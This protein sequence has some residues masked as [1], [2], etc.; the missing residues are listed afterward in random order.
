MAIY[1]WRFPHTCW[2]PRGITGS[3]IQSYGSG[4]HFLASFC[5]SPDSLSLTILLLNFMI[6]RMKLFSNANSSIYIYFHLFHWNMKSFGLLVIKNLYVGWSPGPAKSPRIEEK[7]LTS[8]LKGA[9]SYRIKSLYLIRPHISKVWVP[10]S[11]W[12]QVFIICGYGVRV[13]FNKCIPVFSEALTLR[14]KTN[15]ISTCSLCDSGFRV[16]TPNS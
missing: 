6:N 13:G 7:V 5:S 3:S 4:Y 10:H 16:R 15:L 12:P 1:K 14:N 9:G 8:R 11:Q 2:N